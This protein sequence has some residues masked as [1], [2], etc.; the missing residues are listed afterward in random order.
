[1]SVYLWSELDRETL[2]AVLPDALVVL[3][4][5]AVE[6][7]GPHLP[8]G[9]DFMLAS[10]LS[11]RAAEAAARDLPR[12]IVIAPLMAVGASD[13]HLPFGGTVSFSA[14]TMLAAV[15]DLL[16]SIGASGARRIVIINGHGGNSGIC[17]TAAAA[18]S[19][20]SELTVAHVDYWRTLPGNDPEVPGHAGRFETSLVLAI[21]PELVLGRIA[22]ND[23]PQYLGVVGAEVH[24]A[25]EWKRID[26]FTD[27]PEN[28]S[29]EHGDLLAEQLVA[30]L[31][32]VLRDLGAT[33]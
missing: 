30:G 15:T 27:H 9:T 24:S 17:R 7:H 18:V 11:R 19:S 20:H 29:A 26:G 3:P 13:H 32:G 14:A 4:L 25:A 1:M 6:Q 12:D 16:T 28:G 31:A 22:R 8:T 10:S 5:G 33:L 21:R 2:T 23:P